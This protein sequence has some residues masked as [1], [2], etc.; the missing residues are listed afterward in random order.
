M[1]AQQTALTSRRRFGSGFWK[2]L[3]V[4]ALIVIGVFVALQWQKSREGHA[5]QEFNQIRALYSDVAR[6]VHTDVRADMTP[7]GLNETSTIEDVWSE[8]IAE[9]SGFDRCPSCDCRMIINPDL[10]AWRYQ[11]RKISDL[12]VVCV[13]KGQSRHRGVDF[14][15]QYVEVDTDRLPAWANP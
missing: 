2:I 8:I 15:S 9:D 13:R 12:A 10:S 4:L 1:D 14:H 3:G 6:I 11:L 7:R 5:K